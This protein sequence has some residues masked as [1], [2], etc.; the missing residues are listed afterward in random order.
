MFFVDKFDFSSDPPFYD[1]TLV[2][3]SDIDLFE[4]ARKYRDY[5]VYLN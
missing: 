5:D 1:P 4:W 3:E 2:T